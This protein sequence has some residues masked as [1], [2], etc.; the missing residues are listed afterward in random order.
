M[1]IVW[2][3]D[4][5]AEYLEWHTLDRKVW[6]KINELIKAIQRDP[7]A[8]VG[9]PELLSNNLSG[10]ASRHI[11][12]EHRLVY[13]VVDDSTAFEILSVKYHY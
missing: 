13:R 10:W 8:G 4:A 7:G 2:H 3:P 5:W 9:H 6:K 12:Q 11:T 1:K